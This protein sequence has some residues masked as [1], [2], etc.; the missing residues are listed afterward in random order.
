MPALVC[1]LHV[2][3]NGNFTND[4]QCKKLSSAAIHEHGLLKQ[5]VDVYAG[6]YPLLT[7]V[8]RKK[9]LK[10]QSLEADTPYTP[11]FHF[12]FLFLSPFSFVAILVYAMTK[13]FM[14][15]IPQGSIRFVSCW[16]HPDVDETTE[17]TSGSK[18]APFN[19]F[20]R[21]ASGSVY[22]SLDT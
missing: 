20:Y 7:V 2:V 16:T 15:G 3:L 21:P 5:A 11:F 10:I 18:P 13:M 12:L 9:V 1:N 8:M 6:I 22:R 4:F 14:S 19:L 17:I